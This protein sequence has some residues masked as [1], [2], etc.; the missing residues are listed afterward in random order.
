MTDGANSTTHL[1]DS[2]ISSSSSNND[3]IKSQSKTM[4]LYNVKLKKIDA[5]IEDSRQQIAKHMKLTRSLEKA[6]KQTM[7]IEQGLQLRIAKSLGMYTGKYEKYLKMIDAKEG[8]NM[9]FHLDDRVTYLIEQSCY[10]RIMKEYQYMKDPRK[11]FPNGIGGVIYK[12]YKSYEDKDLDHIYALVESN[13]GS[14]MLLDALFHMI[15]DISDQSISHYDFN[16]LYHRFIQHTYHNVHD[17]D[18]NFQVSVQQL[19]GEQASYLNSDSSLSLNTKIPWNKMISMLQKR[20]LLLSLTKAVLWFLQNQPQET[21]HFHTPLS[22]SASVSVITSSIV[23]HNNLNS[24]G[25]SAKTLLKSI[26]ST[27]KDIYDHNLN[28][29]LEKS[30][31]KAS[32]I[33][34]KILSSIS[35]MYGTELVPVDMIRHHK[36]ALLT[37]Q[38]LAV[39]K[40]F[41]SLEKIYEKFKHRMFERWKKTIE[42]RNIDIICQ[43]FLIQSAAY[44]LQQV[45]E[46]SVVKQL[47][48]AFKCMKDATFEM[49]QLKQLY[50]L[51]DIQRCW[52][53]SRGRKIYKS[54]LRWRASIIIQSAMRMKLGKKR[55]QRIRKEKLLHRNE[56]ITIQRLKSNKIYRSFKKYS[57]IYLM[58]INTLIIQRIYRGHRGRL[59]FEGFR[60]IQRRNIGALAFQTLVRTYLAKR[61]VRQLLLERRQLKCALLIQTTFRR[62]LA[63]LKV[64]YLKKLHNYAKII[65]YLFLRYMAYKEKLKKIR[66]KSAIIIQSVIRG[67]F[68]RKRYNYFYELKITRGEA[69]WNAIKVISPIILGYIIRKRWTKKIKV[70]SIIRNKN[71]IIIQTILCAIVLGQKARKKVK[72]IRKDKKIL[73]HRNHAAIEIQRIQRGIIGRMKFKNYMNLWLIQQERIQNRLPYYYRYK[74]EYYRTQN[75]FHRKYIVKI[76]C[77]IRIKLARFHVKQRRYYL[78]ARKIQK[79][80]RNH[81]GIKKAKIIIER[82]KSELHTQGFSIVGI[83]KIIRGFLIRRRL[84]KLR[85]VGVLKWFLFELRLQIISRE[86]IKKLK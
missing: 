23:K 79:M 66:I 32:N 39:E 63:C 28:E 53:G 74:Y 71:A 64:S 22:S 5:S 60:L 48:R 6:K 26:N 82:R 85:N 29:T 56:L 16:A 45:L 76:Q 36:K 12:A 80:I 13:I 17:S 38:K 57:R 51:M 18:Q 9:D 77:A 62:Y 34:D 54:K 78:A 46:L 10:D 58:K 42:I 3:Y 14:D 84:C 61:R 73:K 21:F 2:A 86:A 69:L 40:L 20:L 70:N 59:R 47:V 72:Q 81:V 30:R 43:S 50:A 49:R 68:G 15:D 4:Q 35:S 41:S 65:Q 25:K 83:Q 33:Q 31:L 55:V 37:F 24:K 8:V 27:Q 7:A 19:S 75:L 44:Q 67:K 52:R 1:F 11:S